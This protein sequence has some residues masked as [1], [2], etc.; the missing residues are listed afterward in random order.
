MEKHRASHP[1]NSLVIL[2]PGLLVLF[3][4]IAILP[5]VGQW[6]A[7]GKKTSD[8]PD[9]KSLNGFG[10]H[11]LA[12]TNPRD[13][14]QQWLKSAPPKLTSAT[15]VESGEPLGLL[16]LF[17][18]CKEVNGACNSEVD[19]AIYK[20]DGSIF[21]E[22]KAQPL[23]KEPAPPKPNI[24]LGRAILAFAFPKGQPAGKYK[25][26][27]KVRDINADISFALETQLELKD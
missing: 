9:R 22:R 17:A 19:Y 21:V 7:D 5:V 3:L 12:V 11:L 24:Q 14:I 2:I 1:I 15:N 23:W 27:A 6:K 18:G 10:A 8:S 25:I 4:W 16:V 26:L 20:P 13:F